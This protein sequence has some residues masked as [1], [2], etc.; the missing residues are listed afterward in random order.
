MKIPA[1]KKFIALGDLRQRYG[2]V[3]HMTIERLLQSDPAFPRPIKLN[4]KG[5]RLWCVEELEA[6]E[7]RKVLARNRSA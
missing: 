2:G 6:Y 3:S 4:P 1:P 5:M 7:R